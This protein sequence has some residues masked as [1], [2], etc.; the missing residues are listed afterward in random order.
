MKRPTLR[1]AVVCAGLAALGATLV[2][3]TS[4]GAASGIVIPAGDTATLSN[5]HFGDGGATNCPAD[6]L[7]YGYQVSGGASATQAVATEGTD[8]ASAGCTTVA[9]AT[10]GP[11]DAE[12]TLTIYLTDNH[13]NCEGATYYSDGTANEA[14]GDADHALVTAESAGSYGVSITDCDEGSLT[15]SERVPTDGHGNFNVTVTI[16]YG[17]PTVS[18]TNPASNADFT[19]NEQESEEFSCADPNGPPSST[20][21]CLDGNGNP[22]GTTLDTSS[23]GP[24]SITVNATSSDGLTATKTY[25]YTVYGPPTVSITNP[26]SNADFTLN[27]QE[28]E[29]FSCADPNGPPSS[30]PT[31]LDGNGNPSGT[32]LDTSSAGPHSITVNATSSDGLTATKTYDYTVYGPPTVSITN[33][34]S[35]ADFT[36]NEQ[37]SEEFSCADPNGPPSSTPTCLDGNGNPSGTTLDTSSAGPH[38]ITVDATSSDG[39]TAT[40]TYDYT[41][42]GPPT[43]SI[44]NPASNA[45]FTLNEQESEEFSCAD[46]NGP[47]S[48]TPTCLDGNGNPSGTTLDTSSAGPHSITVNATSSDGLT[49]TKTYDYTVYGTPTATVSAP[50]SGGIYYVGQSVPTTY[51]CGEGTDGPGLTSCD[52]SYGSAGSTTGTNTGALNTSAAG[53]YSYTVK[54]TS[55]DGQATTSTPVNYTVA[56]APTATIS[57]PGDDQTYDLNQPVPTSFSCSEG[58]DGPGLASCTDSNGA[59]SVSGDSGSGTG[60]LVTSSVGTSIPYTVTVDSSDGQTGSATIHYSVVYVKPANTVP[61]AIAGTAQQGAGLSTTGGTWTGDPAPTLTY[62][63]L[64]CNANGG[65]CANITGEQASG[66]VPSA[67]DVGHTLE[68]TVTG[69]NPGGA[70]SV[71]SQPSAVVLIAAPVNQTAPSI[72]GVAQQNQTLTAQPGTWDPAA[73]GYGYQ[74]WSCD[75]TGNNCTILT[76]QQSSTYVPGTTDVGNTLRV[77]VTASNNGGS[78]SARSGPSQVVAE[79]GAPANTA[80]PA[81]SG[82]AQQNDKLS[83]TEGTWT[84]SPGTY[85]YQ[86]SRCD[87]TSGVCTPITDAT[88]SAWVL[89]SADVGDTLE[90]TVTASN[91]TGGTPA[92]SAQTKVVLPPAPVNSSLPTITGTAAQGDLLSATNGGWQYS[93]YS[94]AY[95][96]WQCDPTGANCTQLAAHGPGYVPA[97]TDVG[98]TLKVTVTATNDGGSTSATSAAS[99]VVLAPTPAPTPTNTPS[100]NLAPP[101][102]GSSTNLNPVSGTILI[103]LPGSNTFVSVPTGTNVPIGST[104]NADSGTVS[105]T[106]ALPNG[107][108]E[109]G[110]FYD[111]EFVLTQAPDG[112]FTPVITGGS[113]TGCPG[114]KTKKGKHSSRASAASSKKKPGTVVRQLWGN[115]HGNYTTKGRYGSAS[116]SGTIWL[117]QDRCDGTFIFALKDDV[118]VIAYAHPHHRIHILQGQHILIPPPGG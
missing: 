89:G 79:I 46:P 35:N 2:L 48:S 75:S 110:E 36:L 96:W 77:V 34:A 45:D 23:A 33:P 17:P 91:S 86:W 27:E 106:L 85:T 52:P 102:L 116:V 72:S 24:H 15:T 31:C 21:T 7:T 98:R 10:I 26:A 80:A 100:V 56:A 90:V 39:L 101:V 70:V 13:S 65:G 8:G 58:A 109:T 9:G 83:A 38:S 74:W 28:S 49:A 81:I 44:T 92:T 14:A 88:S 93:P 66:Y 97:S 63:W 19:L 32:T 40:K 60:A 5:A 22:S 11:F 99:D 59:G 41:V 111:G 4:A 50:N 112:T 29:E 118:Y 69:T 61:P 68:V 6:N 95:Q 107:T 37:E 67:G 104:V 54:A 16:N 103:E 108:T 84:N 30:T 117:V 25:D 78:N 64:Q 113:F 94:F 105:I 47:P 53:H 18:I 87:P 73:T 20:P 55:S 57:T 3:A 62:Q 114:A 43:V 71:T 1:L 42:Y 12:T 115:A 51:S 76:G 82:T